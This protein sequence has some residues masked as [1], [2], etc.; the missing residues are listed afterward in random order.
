MAAIS[1]PASKYCSE[2]LYRKERSERRVQK[3]VYRKEGTERKVQNGGYRKGGIQDEVYRN[4]GT[5]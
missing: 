5:G 3:G 4:E 1:P 2:F